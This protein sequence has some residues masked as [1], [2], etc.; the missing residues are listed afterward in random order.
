MEFEEGFGIGWLRAWAPGLVGSRH[1]GRRRSVENGGADPFE[2]WCLRTAI[3][4]VSHK[5]RTDV[6]G[7]LMNLLNARFHLYER[8]IYHPT[9]CAAG[10]MLGTALQLIGWRKRDGVALLSF[11]AYFQRLGDDVFIH[12]LREI[13]RLARSLLRTLSPGEPLD[14]KLLSGLTEARTPR[15]RLLIDVLAAR[16]GTPTD[17][18]LTDLNAASHILD[19]LSSRRFPRPIF[20]ALP[21]SRDLRLEAGAEALAFTFREPDARFKAERAI[22]S[23]AGLPRGSVFIHCP[24]RATAEKVANVL[25]VRRGKEGKEEICKLRNVSQLDPQVFGQHELAIQAV[26]KMYRS[27]W[28]LVVYVAQEHVAQ[29]EKIGKA[30]GSVLFAALDVHEHFD[31]GQVWQNDEQ[32]EKE[33]EG[34][35]S[36]DNGSSEMEREIVSS[37]LSEIVESKESPELGK[38]VTDGVLSPLGHD[39]RRAHLAAMLTGSIAME[40]SPYE[41]DDLLEIVKGYFL[42]TLPDKR[43]RA[44]RRRYANPW[45]G[46]QRQQRQTVCT[47]LRRRIENTPMT[48]ENRKGAGCST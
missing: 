11:P 44:L 9:K 33:L 43:S 7:E 32:L 23:E 35:F 27:M 20:R 34:Q 2:G 15:D 46:M 29:H 3:S 40:Q 5:Y 12:E 47:K 8:A 14:L 10:A 26:E 4:L 36:T 18:T 38:L 41:I 37:T 28:R 17:D 39:D 24:R 45:M 31:P 13:L 1:D 6:P 21:S 48:L 25:L 19:R 22:E 30:A 42:R 16:V